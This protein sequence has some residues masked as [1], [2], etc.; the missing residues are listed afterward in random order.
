[1]STAVVAE[2]ASVSVDIPT[3]PAVEVETTQADRAETFTVITRDDTEGEHFSNLND[4]LFSG[5]PGVVTSRRSETGFGGPN[6]GFLIR[7]LQGPHVPVFVDGIPI[8]VNNHFHARVDRYSSDMIDRMKITRGASVLEH[9]ASAVAGAVDIYTRKPGKGTSGFIESSYGTYRSKEVFGDIGYGWDDGSILFSA[10][11]KLTDGPP[12]E[13]QAD[14][15][16]A[17][18]LT[19]LNLKINQAI[20]N[21]WSVGLRASNAKEV[22]EHFPYAYGVSYRRFGQ[23]E[24]DLVV[25]LDR[26]T[27][28]S[29]TLIALHDDTLDNYNGHYTNGAL[30][31]GTTIST[32]KE[33][34]TGFLIKHTMLRGGGNNTTFGFHKVKYTDDRFEANDKKSKGN[35]TSAYVQASQGLDNDVRITGGVR[36]TKGSDFSTNISPEIG[37]VKKI[38]ATLALR[39]RAGK[40]FRVPRIG[41]T[42][43]SFASTIKPEDFRHAEVGLNKLTHGG[44]ELDIAVWWMG[45][46]NL[47]VNQGG[48]GAS[49]YYDNSGKFNNR[50]IEALLSHKISSNLSAYLAATIMSLDTTN[51]SP[52][53]FFD[54][55]IEYRQDALRAN[56]KIRDARRN[57]NPNLSDEDYTVLD[58]RV[59]YALTKNAT[60]FAGVDNIT[61]TRYITYVDRFG[62]SG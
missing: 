40:A 18:D 54:A 49:S 20:N 39:A 37:I 4:A 13:G 31:A 9:G 27:A 1:M 59:Q 2:T 43:A 56:L 62:A 7:G 5:T 19:N 26:K 60:I 28:D 61:D 53:T 11:D 15:Y 10:S 34:E 48:G 23:N 30:N 58:G 17:H 3:L 44:G 45:G 32:R 14:A 42:D 24:T 41:E 50:G 21:E 46:K 57:A 36:V 35:H 52:Q 51:S 22:P 29:S 55:G 25:H 16:E 6:S 8:Q 47:I 33:T 12:I 38:D